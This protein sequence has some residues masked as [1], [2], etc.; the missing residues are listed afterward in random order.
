MASAKKSSFGFRAH[1]IERMPARVGW[2]AEISPIMST[3]SSS[4]YA[5]VLGERDAAREL[6]SQALLRFTMSREKWCAALSALNPL[7]PFNPLGGRRSFEGGNRLLLS[8]SGQGYPL[9]MTARQVAKAGGSVREGAQRLPVEFWAKEPF[10]QRANVSVSAPGGGTYRVM[11]ASPRE[12][13]VLVAGANRLEVPYKDRDGL[14][15]RFGAA[16][17]SASQSLSWDEADSRYSVFAARVYQVVNWANVDGVGQDKLSERGREALGA[18]WERKGLGSEA[19]AKLG[20]RM[21]EAMQ[22]SGVSVIE[23]SSQESSYEPGKDTLMVPSPR[24]AG[25]MSSYVVGLAHGL[26]HATGHVRRLGRIEAGLG[27]LREGQSAAEQGLALEELRAELATALFCAEHALPYEMTCSAAYLP[28]WADKLQT[29]PDEAFL[30]ARDAYASVDMMNAAVRGRPMSAS[31][32][33]APN[34]HADMEM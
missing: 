17:S 24:K 34:M 27:V 12:G 18:A 28:M 1:T 10:W 23:A 4:L 20:V 29:S 7:V 32:D 25:S 30:A 2:V 9:W 6:L 33:A 3:V 21:V 15:A 8:L 11:F 14:R 13:I 31:K 19:M 26:A 5:G 22:R 16:G